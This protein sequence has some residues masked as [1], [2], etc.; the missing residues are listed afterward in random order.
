MISENNYLIPDRV[1]ASYAVADKYL[2]VVTD[3]EQ[4]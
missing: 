4:E 3:L 2:L 1:K